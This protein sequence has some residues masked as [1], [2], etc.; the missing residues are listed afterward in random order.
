MFTI[1]FAV[2]IIVKSKLSLRD[3]ARIGDEADML[4]KI[5]H[6]NIVKIHGVYDTP[7]KLYLVMDYLSGGELF[8]RIVQQSH[9]SE[10][11]AAQMVATL[12]GAIR[13]MHA[14]G[15]VHRDLST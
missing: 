7:T 5:D 8:D 1:Q 11:A 6:P 9:F 4:R 15:I 13:H 14:R 3:L 2:K 10:L 12:I